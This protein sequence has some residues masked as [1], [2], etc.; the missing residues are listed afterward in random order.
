MARPESLFP[1]N[2]A[3]P[4]MTDLYELTMAA[5][6]FITGKRPTASFEA[7]VRVLPANRSFL[8]AAGLEQALQYVL[9]LRFGDETIRWMRQLPTFAHVPAAFFEYL[10]DFRFHGNVWAIPEGTVVFAQEPLIRI[11]GDLI[12]TQI[13]ETYLLTCLNLQTLVASKSARIVTAAA[14]RQ[15]MEFGARR[16]HGPQAGLLAARAAIIG[17]CAGTS[18]VE[19]ARVLGVPAMGTMAHSWVMAFADEAEA[20]RRFQEIF[21]Q[22]AICL[23]DTY[24]TLAGAEKAARALGPRL[25]GVRLDSGDLLRLSRQVRRILD[26]NGCSAAKIVASNDLNEFAIHDLV[27]AGAPIDSFGV[28]TDMVTSRDAPALSLV[29]KLIATRA[30]DGP[31]QAVAKHSEDK[32]TLGGRKQVWRRYDSKGRTAG[33]VVG[34]VDE[35]SRG[36]PL[37]EPFIEAGRLVRELPDVHEIAART[38]RQLAT[39]PADTLE[40]PGGYAYPVEIS[41]ALKEAQPPTV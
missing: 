21:P 32:T 23:I 33:D 38:R 20:F 30:A 14:G 26:E 7:H 25:T 22:Q 28:G 6:Y 9:N 11:E 40:L 34:T 37:L 10:H 1:S 19:A 18:Q 41:Q 24:N 39:L 8:V 5:G 35:V 27:A 3:L 29:Y 36:E 12:E 31:W 15:V 17:G 2:A 16:A 13:L 4:L